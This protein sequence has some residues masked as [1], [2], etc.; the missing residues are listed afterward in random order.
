MYEI[1]AGD[2]ISSTYDRSRGAGTYPQ[3]FALGPKKTAKTWLFRPDGK[4]K[5]MWDQT[6]NTEGGAASVTINAD[7][8]SGSFTIGPYTDR[9]R[10]RWTVRGTFACSRVMATGL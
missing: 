2:R 5:R 6:I 9:T 10:K 8:R 4:G 7:E 3:H 1:L